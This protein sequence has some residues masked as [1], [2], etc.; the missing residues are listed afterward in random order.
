MMIVKKFKTMSKKPGRETGGE[1]QGGTDLEEESCKRHRQRAWR[2]RG[3]EG[4]GSLDSFTFSPTAIMPF[5]TEALEV[6][7]RWSISCS[8]N[9]SGRRPEEPS[10]S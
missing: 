6:G 3:R 7:H 4:R 2:R 10:L 8:T 1:V 5:Y 9:M